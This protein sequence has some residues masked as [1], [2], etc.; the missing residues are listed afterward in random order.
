VRSRCAGNDEHFIEVS[1][2]RGD[3]IGVGQRFSLAP[4]AYRLFA[5][6]AG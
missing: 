4:R 5:S 6:P 3:A 2:P 1:A